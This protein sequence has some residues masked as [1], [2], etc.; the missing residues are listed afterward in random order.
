LWRGSECQA[1]VCCL[2]QRMHVARDCASARVSGFVTLQRLKTNKKREVS[3]KTSRPQS[4]KNAGFVD[5][6]ST[7]FLRRQKLTK[8]LESTKFLVFFLRFLTLFCEKS[9]EKL[10]KMVIQYSHA[11]R[12]YKL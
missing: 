9:R 12:C 10:S 3:R 11:K 5:E 6:M 8:T 2:L 4:T 1:M 7:L